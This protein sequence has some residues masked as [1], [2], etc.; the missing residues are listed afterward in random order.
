MAVKKHFFLW[1]H[2]WKKLS[3]IT[4]FVRENWYHK[5]SCFS[6]F[7]NKN[8]FLRTELVWEALD[9]H[10]L[11]RALP[12]IYHRIYCRV[13]LTFPQLS[14]SAGSARSWFD[15]SV[16]IFSKYKSE[17]WTRQKTHLVRSFTSSSCAIEKGFPQFSHWKKN[18]NSDWL[19]K[20]ADQLNILAK[21]LFIARWP[22]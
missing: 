8:C 11:N 4:L 22:W 15:D 13:M 7:Y 17:V 2:W 9:S 10:T 20:T 21:S 14:G 3:P 6:I 12:Q 19:K 5:L 16:R 1:L 18:R